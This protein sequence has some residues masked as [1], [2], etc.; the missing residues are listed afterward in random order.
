MH[1]GLLGFSPSSRR[2]RFTV[3]ADA[4]P[5]AGVVS[6]HQTPSSNT[7]KISNRPALTDSTKGSSYP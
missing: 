1:F 5:A 4:P 2:S 3:G 6:G 7:S